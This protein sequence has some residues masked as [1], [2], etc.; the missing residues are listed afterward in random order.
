METIKTT[1]VVED[2]EHLK[3]PHKLDKLKKGSQVDLLIVLRKEK[4]AKNNWKQ[5]LLNI[6][7]YSEEQLSDF[8]VS[9]KEFNKWQPSEF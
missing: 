9:R 1:A 5:I 7:T 2:D 3:L 6:G 4:L 8:A